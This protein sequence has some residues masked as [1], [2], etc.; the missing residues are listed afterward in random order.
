ME[1]IKIANL[2]A[3]YQPAADDTK[4]RAVILL[5]G[6][7]VS[8]VDLALFTDILKNSSHYH[9]FFP[10]AP[11]TLSYYDVLPARTWFPIDQEKFKQGICS[12]DEDHFVDACQK[13]SGFV[14]ELQK[15]Y[16]YMVLGGFS[17]GSVLS[18]YLSLAELKNIYKLALFSTTLAYPERW[19]LKANSNLKVLQSHG[20]NDPVLPISAARQVKDLLV[21]A[22][23]SVEY[24]EFSGG[25]EIPLSVLQDFD[26]FLELSEGCHE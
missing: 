7:G 9:W 17:Q 18:L 11:L 24:R 23:I 19:D 22:K 20:L 2:K 3:I 26:R 14:T 5:H 6:Y 8:M 16:Q 12:W 15:E 25:H 4:K 10:D 1:E 21:A 13:V